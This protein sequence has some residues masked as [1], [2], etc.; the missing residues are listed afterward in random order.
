MTDTPD[1]PP[2]PVDIDAPDVHEEAADVLGVHYGVVHTLEL[3]QDAI[4][5]GDIPEA[6]TQDHVDAL[7]AAFRTGERIQSHHTYEAFLQNGLDALPDDL[8]DDVRE[9]IAPVANTYGIDL[10]LDHAGDGVDLADH[11]TAVMTA[12]RAGV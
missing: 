6:L 3:V 11:L 2:L 9:T 4:A 12:W 7:E 10:E 8:V 5:E 1:D